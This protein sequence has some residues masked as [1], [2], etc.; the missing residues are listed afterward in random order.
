MN[1][2]ANQLARRLKKCGVDPEKIVGVC[3]ERSIEMAVGMLAILKAG[4]AYVPIDPAYP[5]DRIEYM[6]EDSGL[7]VILT[8]ILTCEAIKNQLP[9]NQAQIICLDS[10]WESISDESGDNLPVDTHPDNLAYVIYTSGSTGKPKGTMLRHRGACNLAAA[11][12]KAFNVK[13]GSRI[14]QFASLSFDAATWEFVMAMLSGA[15]LI[16]TNRETIAAGQEL[17]KVMGDQK[18]TAIT[19]PPSVLAVLP[20]EILPELQTIITAGEAVSGDLVDKWGKERQFFNAYGPTETTVCASMHLCEGSYPQ[21]PPI[22]NPIANFKLYILDKHLQPVPVGVSGEL[23]IDGVG[24]ARGYLNRPALTADKFI[25]NPFSGQPGA[26][27][28]RSGDLARYLPDGN[29]EFLGR[30]DFQV[31][32]RGFRIELGEIEALLDQRG[33]I[34]DVIVL[35]REDTPGSQRLAAYLVAQDEVELDVS[36]IKKYLR[37]RLPDY[38]VPSSFVIL[39]KLPLTPNGKIDRKALPAPEITRE[40][41]SAEYAPPTNEAEEKLVKIVGKLLNIKKVGI[42]DNFFE[43]GGHSLLATQFMSRLRTAFGVELPL[44]T[45]FEKPTSAQIAEEIEKAKAQGQTAQAAP[46]IKRVSRTARKIKRS[47]LD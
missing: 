35:A 34:K 31:K 25:P 13:Q 26:R 46:T 3:I 30:I 15:A 6:I 32:V 16:L 37:E 38:M 24:L 28:Y 39:D 7:S 45:L 27:L 23:C 14:M 5:K 36:E 8:V 9:Q 44:K 43:L 22:G 18:V 12:I 41:L 4:G 21:G 1:K 17:V 29:V 20:Q 40:D 19:L 11:Q 33:E 2:R 47:D 10:E 42:N